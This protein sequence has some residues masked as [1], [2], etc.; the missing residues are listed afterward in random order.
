MK[1]ASVQEWVTGVIIPDWQC[2]Q[3]LHSQCQHQRGFLHLS[4]WLKYERKCR[5]YQPLSHLIFLD[6]KHFLQKIWTLEWLKNSVRANVKNPQTCQDLQQWRVVVCSR[7]SP[8]FPPRFKWHFH[9]AN[10]N[11]RP[12]RISTCYFPAWLVKGIQAALI[13]YTLLIYRI[14]RGQFAGNS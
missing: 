8:P 2:P 7:H 9:V 12:S 14:R 3:L 6:G 5:K 4:T 13:L 10:K 11:Y 1:E